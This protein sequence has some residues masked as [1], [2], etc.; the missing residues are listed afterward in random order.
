MTRNRW[1]VRVV[2]GLAL[3]ALLAAGCGEG[4]D[5]ADITLIGAAVD[6]TTGQSS[7]FDITMTYEGVEQLEGA[8]IVAGGELIEGSGGGAMRMSM[9]LTEIFEASGAPVPGG[10]D[11][12]METIIVGSDFYM[13]GAAFSEIPGVDDGQYLHMD[14]SEFA[15]VGQSFT[16]SGD[17]RDTLEQLKASGDV[18]EIGE[19]EVRGVSTRQYRARVRMGDALEQMDEDQRASLESLYGTDLERLEDVEFEMDVYI[20]GDD[21]VRRM[22]QDISFE[23]FADLTSEPMPVELRGASLS[24]VMDFFDYGADVRIEAPTDTVEFSEVEDLFAS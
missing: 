9:D 22:T 12:T 11:L 17:P 14:L 15:D 16:G 21:L 6:N 1:I 13:G 19:A 23:D 20:D 3:L 10:A 18:D 8:S 2:A 5:G 24:T 7:R 4:D